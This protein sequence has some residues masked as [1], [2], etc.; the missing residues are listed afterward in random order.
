MSSPRDQTGASYPSR[1][2]RVAPLPLAETLPRDARLG[3]AATEPLLPGVPHVVPEVAQ[4]RDITGDPV[5]PEVP[6]QL[7]RQ[8]GPLLPDRVMAMLAAPRRHRR[9][10]PA[11]PVL[12]RLAL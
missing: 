11:E 6:V 1:G 7:P 8:G 3:R 2:Q 12:G 5:I 4:A 10:G 9:Q